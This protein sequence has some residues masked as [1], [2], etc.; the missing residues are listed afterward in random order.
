MPAILFVPGHLTA[1]FP[2]N[3]K[4]ALVVDCGFRET[5]ILPVCDPVLFIFQG[6][7]F[8]QVLDGVTVLSSLEVSNISGRRLE[9]KVEELLKEHG[10]TES[11][12]GQK[13]EKLTEADC[14]LIRVGCC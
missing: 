5:V 11:A 8:N 6:E 10:W 7:Y 9:E 14:Q 3:T 12:D 1:T 4:D 13:K 2:F